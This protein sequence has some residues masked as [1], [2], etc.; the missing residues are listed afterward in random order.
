M[1]RT[2]LICKELGLNQNKLDKFESI[3][4]LDT[5]L[6]LLEEGVQIENE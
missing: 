1:N 2:E 4:L 6:F 3:V 5:L